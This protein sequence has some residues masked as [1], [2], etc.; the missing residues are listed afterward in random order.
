VQGSINGGGPVLRLNAPA[1][2]IYL[3]KIK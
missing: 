1:G 2:V 3:K